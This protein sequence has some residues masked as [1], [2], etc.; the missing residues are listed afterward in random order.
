[1][2]SIYGHLKTLL[3]GYLLLMLLLLLFPL[4][5]LSRARQIT[6]AVA[7]RD[8]ASRGAGDCWR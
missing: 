3:Q 4:G 8:S 5:P 1:M 7:G 6:C 2:Y